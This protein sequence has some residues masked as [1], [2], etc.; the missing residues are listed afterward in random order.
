MCFVNINLRKAL[1]FCVDVGEAPGNVTCH[2]FLWMSSVNGP[3][4]PGAVDKTGRLL[5]GG[6]DLERL[7]IGL[8]YGRKTVTG[9]AQHTR[10][11]RLG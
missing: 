8:P 2:W 4:V 11:L 1:T 5:C 7:F 3:G 9:C 10:T 6:E